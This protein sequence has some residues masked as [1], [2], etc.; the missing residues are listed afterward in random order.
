MQQL[1]MTLLDLLSGK[2]KLMCS[3]Y[4]NDKGS[5]EEDHYEPEQ[6]QEEESGELAT[7]TATTSF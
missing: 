1:W 5:R 3:K 2:E 4:E 6:K 7:T